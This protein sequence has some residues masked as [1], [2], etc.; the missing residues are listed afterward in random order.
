MHTSR[1]KQ[2]GQS[3]SCSRRKSSTEVKARVA[4]PLACS[5]ALNAF[6]NLLSSSSKK[7][8]GS[9]LVSLPAECT[10]MGMGGGYEGLAGGR[11]GLRSSFFAAAPTQHNRPSAADGP[12]LNGAGLRGA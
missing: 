3:R 1:T 11:G 10:Y 9:D 6:A 2:P 5:R 4:K 7:T 8:T 12:R